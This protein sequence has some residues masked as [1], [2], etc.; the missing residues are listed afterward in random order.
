MASLTAHGVGR[1][2]LQVVAHTAA[3]RAFLRL[4][5]GADNQPIQGKTGYFVVIWRVEAEA[6]FDAVR[7]AGL[8]VVEQPFR[9]LEWW[10]SN[11]WPPAA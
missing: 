3:G 8:T 4:H 9:R 10:S 6:L 5:T 2:M 1:S 7:L 11:N